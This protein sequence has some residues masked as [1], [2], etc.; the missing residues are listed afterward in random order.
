VSG[1]WVAERWLAPPG[2]R[3]R[4]TALTQWRETLFHDLCSRP[5]VTSTH[6]CPDSRVKRLRAFEPPVHRLPY[7]AYACTR[8]YRPIPRR[9]R[10][11]VAGG[12]DPRWC[13]VWATRSPAATP[14]VLLSGSEARMRLL[15]CDLLVRRS[16]TWDGCAADVPCHTPD[17]TRENHEPALG[18]P[19]IH[20]LEARQRLAVV[21]PERL[22]PTGST[23]FDP[24]FAEARPM[25]ATATPACAPERSFRHGFTHTSCALGL[26]GRGYSPRRLEAACRLST[27]AIE[28]IREHTRRPSELQHLRDSKLPLVGRRTPKGPPTRLSTG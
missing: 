11:A 16:R 15:T 10:R 7:D 18:V 1:T 26:A 24:A 6:Q 8:R 19:R 4:V 22:P 25:A 27:S 2:L 17:T 20:P 28:T 13:R 9:R 23:E 21:N 12:C 3:V 5:V 14:R